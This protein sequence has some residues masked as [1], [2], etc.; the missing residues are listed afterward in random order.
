MRQWGNGAIGELRDVGFGLLAIGQDGIGASASPTPMPSVARATI[1]RSSE[2]L[3]EGRWP[4]M[5]KHGRIAFITTPIF[6]KSRQKDFKE[7]VYRRM[8]SLC[9]SFDVVTTGRTYKDIRR[10]V[11]ARPTPRQRR[12]IEEDTRFPVSTPADLQRWRDAI[13]PALVRAKSSFPGMIYLAYELVEGRIDAV[14]HLNDWQDKSA[15]PDSAVLSREANVHKVPIAT[16]PETAGAYIESWNASLAKRSS[17][18]PIFRK[19][20]Q[21]KEP[22]LKG[23]KKGDRVIAMVA[24]NNMK[25]DLCLF[26]IERA[27]SIFKNYDYVLATGT[28]GGWLQQFM[29]AAGN[30]DHVQKIRLCNSGPEGGDL[31]IAY[32][33]VEGICSK[34][35]FLQD[36]SVPHPHDSDIRLFEQAVVAKD[37]K[38]QLATNV[39]SARL[40]IEA[41]A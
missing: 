6:R 25:L 38:V 17:G 32:A 15:K 40:L 9:N 39:D 13:L 31:Q 7:F 22:P 24:H 28:T 21:P 16:D 20:D 18:T 5:R 34:V 33:V 30:H 10:L 26:A 12:L 37:V 35:I 36:P 4:R 14:I 23:L 2:P 41:S 1:G 19:R 8:Y 27:K 3:A 29:E 11:R